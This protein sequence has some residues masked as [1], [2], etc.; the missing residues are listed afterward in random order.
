[1]KK[2]RLTKINSY[3]KWLTVFAMGCIFCVNCDAEMDSRAVLRVRA[4]KIVARVS[5]LHAGL[6]TEEINNSFD[7]GLYAE[8]LRDRAMNGGLRATDGALGSWSMV[9]NV[10]GGAGIALDLGDPISSAVPTSMRIDAQTASSTERVGIANSGF[11]GVPVRANTRY[12]L[13]FYA[14]TAEGFS[15]ALVASIE[16]DDGSVVYCRRNISV[17]SGSWNRYEANLDTSEGILPTENARL[18]IATEHPVTFWLA[19][20]SLFPPTWN[21]RPNGNRVDLMKKLAE[22]HPKFLRFPGGGCLSGRTEDTRFDWK[23]TLGPLP[24]RAGH[25]TPWDQWTTDGMG[26]LEFL[27]WCED[28]RLEPVL[29][30]W[31]G[32]SG[33]VELPAGAP[34]E[35]FVQD[36]LSEIEYVSGDASTR[37]GARRAADGHP[38]PFKLTYVEIGNEDGKPGYSARF[39][40]FYDAI[41]ARYPALQMI[42]T[43][44]MVYKGVETLAGDRVKSRVPDILDEHYYNET[45][46]FLA[47]ASQY[48]HYDRNGPKV[49]VGEWATIEGSP[50]PNLHAAL[51]DAAWMIGMERNSDIVIMQAYAPLFVNVNSPFMGWNTSLIGYDS[52]NSYGS[53]SYYA[54]VMFNEHRGDEILEA[55]LQVVPGLFTSVTRDSQT[56]SIIIKA[57]NTR[58]TLCRVRIETL[59]TEPLAPNGMQIVLTGKTDDTNSIEHPKKIVPVESE[60]NGVGASFEHEFPGNSISVL[61]LDPRK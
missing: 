33:S 16:S 1:M 55:P 6:M 39:A 54:Q 22:L 43:G 8:L 38:A 50:T 34:L 10:R 53:P 28:L 7:G 25:A 11:W 49:F 18:V 19:L 36:A 56:G 58:E 13:S 31:A 47:E 42:A 5:P 17:G 60:L 24:N 9:P 23:K 44:R 3:N 48:D 46:D 20:V 29:G 21:N 37:W 52:L 30:V 2:A 12:R 51:G 26:L 45:K 40:Q 27:E 57:V 4:D 14:K 35:P 59:G 61:V 15:G 32:Q 41:K